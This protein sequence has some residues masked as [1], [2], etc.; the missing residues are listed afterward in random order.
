MVKKIV[1]AILAVLLIVVAVAL[2]PGGLSRLQGGDVPPSP[3]LLEESTLTVAE[4]EIPAKDI[5]P[6]FVM[7]NAVRVTLAGERMSVQGVGATLSDDGRVL[8]IRQNGTYVFSGDV[9]DGQI[10]VDVA[11]GRVNLVLNGAAI[12]CERSSPV[13]VRQA[14]SVRVI[15]VDGTENRLSDGAVYEYLDPVYLEPD[16]T[17]FSEDD[18]IFCGSGSLTV[19]GNF[20]DAIH[21][22]DRLVI[23]DL[24]LTVQ[25]KEDGVIA[26]D[27]LLMQNVKIKADCGMDCLKANNPAAG[28]GYI[29]ASSGSYTLTSGHDAIQAEGRMLL[30]GGDYFLLC[31]GGY[32][33]PRGL[34]SKKGLKAIEELVITGGHFEIDSSDDAIHADRHLSVTG[35]EYLIYAGDDALLATEMYIGG[36]KIDVRICL[37]GMVA[38]VM[39]IADGRIHIVSQM[40]GINARIRALLADESFDLYPDQGVTEAPSTAQL[41]ITGGNVVVNADRDAVCVRGTMVMNG[42]LV[43]LAGPEVTGGDPLDCDVSFMMNGGTLVAAGR[44]TYMPALA[45]GSSAAAVEAT[46][47]TAREADSSVS[48]AHGEEVLVTALVPRRFYKMVIFS[49]ALKEGESYMLRAGGAAEEESD[50]IFVGHGVTGDRAIGSFVMR[51]GFVTLVEGDKQFPDN[52]YEDEIL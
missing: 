51:N 38:E 31:G 16:A 6:S 28:L 25:A 32:A 48:L 7:T 39:E 11:Q 43:L 44:T 49:T 36:G 37:E 27:A 18:L 12:H 47:A 24:S 45:K 52:Y 3:S 1:C 33:V 10:I 41:H 35:G 40:D 15:A 21:T 17:V 13:Y 30:T 5:D 14:S 34:E 23:A 20:R 2:L 26:R 22:K 4:T 19:E 50:R 8:T 9:Q 46:F 42:G 29:Y